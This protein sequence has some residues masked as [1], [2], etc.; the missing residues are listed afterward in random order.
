VTW[1]RSAPG[2]RPGGPDDAGVVAVEF[3]LVLP[4]LIVLLF[5]IILGG[6]VY[7]DQL[8]LQSAARNGARVGSVTPTSACHAATTDLA[9][10]DVGTVACE[11]L[12]N[13]TTGTMRLRLT[14][15]QTVP[16]PIVGDRSVTLRA[17]SSYAC[18]R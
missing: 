5:T 18:P 10:N 13:C 3:A 9:G 6:G 16:L 14:A 17:T 1:R 11:V 7:L 12:D 4:L 15:Q 2:S 8:N